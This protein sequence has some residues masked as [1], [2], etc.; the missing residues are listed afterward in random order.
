[1]SSAY[2]HLALLLAAAFWGFGNVAQK[3]VLLHVGPLSATSLRCAVAATVVLPFIFKELRQPRASGWQASSFGVAAAFAIAITFQQ[4][5][6]LYTTVVNG[7]FLVNT[8]T[9]LTPLIAWLSFREKTNRLGLLAASM[10][11]VGVYLM[12]SGVEGLSAMNVGDIACLM[13]AAFYAIWMVLLGRHAQRYGL[14]LMSSFIQFG[15]AALAVLPMSLLLE[16]LS[17]NALAAA[18]PQLAILGIFPTAAAFA[19]Q[20]YAQ[21]Y[22]TAPKAAVIV[23]GES[24]FGAIGA[25]ALLEERPPSVVVV[26]ATIIFLAIVLVSVSHGRTVGLD[27]KEP[28]G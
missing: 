8:A 19:L 23:S 24:I 27:R 18:A 4:S 6:Y 26:G 2:A 28:L 10:T 15:V 5:A 17:T 20:T 14:P 7:S 25:Y 9:V 11:L 3:T 1:M 16:D 12:A 13:S 22:V 21:R